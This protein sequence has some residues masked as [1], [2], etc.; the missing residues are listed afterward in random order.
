MESSSIYSK[1]FCKNFSQSKV[2]ICSNFLR[3]IVRLYIYRNKIKIDT[4][5]KIYSNFAKDNLT[6]N[7]LFEQAMLTMVYNQ[8]NNGKKKCDYQCGQTV[9]RDANFDLN[10]RIC[11]A[12]CDVQWD[13][14]Y[15]QQIQKILQDNPNDQ[16]LQIAGASKLKYAKKRLDGSMKR[17]QKAKQ[18]LRIRRS[19][20]PADMSARIAKPMPAFTTQD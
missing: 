2:N 9:K 18:A 5:L 4:R 15:L 10:L 17:L 6:M 7:F 19:T 1:I 11:R 3:F 8:V 20:P 13:K 14:T 16:K 12:T